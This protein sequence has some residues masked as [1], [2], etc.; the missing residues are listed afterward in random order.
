MSLIQV[1]NNARTLRA[2]HIHNQLQ[3]ATKALD[4][5]PMDFVLKQSCHVILGRA[6][7]SLETSADIQD[8]DLGAA[9]LKVIDHI[10]AIL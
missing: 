4:S 3:A 1:Q 8:L 7:W 5:T 2:L 9:V 6:L 10:T